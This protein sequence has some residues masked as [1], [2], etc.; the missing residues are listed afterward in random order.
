MPIIQARWLTL[1]FQTLYL[2]PKTFLFLQEHCFFSCW[3]DFYV[4]EVDIGSLA[5]RSP[6]PSLPCFLHELFLLTLCHFTFH[7][8]IFDFIKKTALWAYATTILLISNLYSS[9]S[10]AHLSRNICWKFPSAAKLKVQFLNRDFLPLVFFVKSIN[11]NI[12]IWSL[13]CT[14][15]ECT[16]TI[17]LFGAN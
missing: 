14:I 5:K 1:F 15:S 2:C 8:Q 10:F 4:R 11:R 12:R 13:L 16:E 9:N 3:F 6:R 17:I 7:L